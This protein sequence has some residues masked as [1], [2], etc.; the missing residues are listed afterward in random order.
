M[1]IYMN[2]YICIYSYI[3]IHVYIYILQELRERLPYS[4]SDNYEDAVKHIYFS[5]RQAGIFPLWHATGKHA[6]DDNEGGDGQYGS[7]GLE[8]E[9]RKV[10]LDLL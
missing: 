4:F 2:I 9:M 10:F 8:I 7:R 1:Y 5:A 6:D 3:Y